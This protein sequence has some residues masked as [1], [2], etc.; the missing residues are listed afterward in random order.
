MKNKETFVLV[1]LEEEKSKKLAQV[2]SNTTSRKI[3][4]YLSE[5]DASQGDIAKALNLPLSTVDYNIKLLKENDLIIAKDFLWSEKG[6]KIEIYTIA[7]KL[8]VIAP[9]GVKNVKNTLKEILPLTL[10]SLI[11]SGIIYLFTQRKEVFTE[12]A[13]KQTAVQE[14]AQVATIASELVPQTTTMVQP[15]YLWFLFGALFVIFI[16]LFWKILKSKE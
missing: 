2:I 13:L 7:K 6:K 1:S 9:K 12:S 16:Y 4:D 11:A 8:I 15:Y 10:F 5:K 14:G 3:L